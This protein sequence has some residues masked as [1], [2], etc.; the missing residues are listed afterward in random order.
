MDIVQNRRTKIKLV[1]MAVVLALA[2]L[3]PMAVLAKSQLL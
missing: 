1:A 2:T 3:A